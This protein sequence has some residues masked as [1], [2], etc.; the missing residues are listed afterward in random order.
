MKRLFIET[1]GG[2]PRGGAGLSGIA[3]YRGANGT[4]RVPAT[5]SAAAVCGVGTARGGAQ[6]ALLAA[7]GCFI[8]TQVQDGGAHGGALLDARSGR[9]SV[10][11]ATPTK[12]W[13]ALSDLTAAVMRRGYHGGGAGREGVPAAIAR[14]RAVAAGDLPLGSEVERAT[15]CPIAH[16]VFTKTSRSGL[17]KPSQPG[18]GGVHH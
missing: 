15:W 7:L 16:R 6:H 3:G 11:S 18:H 17:F 1:P 10:G 13:R 4:T 8:A 2:P 12:G 5:R 14:G 9:P